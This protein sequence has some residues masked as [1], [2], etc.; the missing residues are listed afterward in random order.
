MQEMIKGILSFFS[1]ATAD[2]A[3]RILGAAA[4]VTGGWF[5]IKY[6]MRLFDRYSY[7]NKLDQG[8]MSFLSSL[9]KIALRSVLFIMAA[10]YLGVPNTSFI[11]ILSSIGLAVSLGLQGS[12]GNFAGGLMLLTFHPFRV[13]DY[14]Q[15]DQ[16]AGTVTSIN[17]LY[18]QL[19][20]FDNKLVIIPN[21]TLSNGVVT[22]YSALDT[23]RVDISFTVGAD[24][25]IDTVK[26]LMTRAAEEH[27][28]VLDDPKPDARMGGMVSG[29]MT[30]T[31]RCWVKT[32]DFWIVTYDL[33]ERLKNDFDLEKIHLPPPQSKV[34][35]VDGRQG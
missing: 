7:S 21:S 18:T 30:F 3:L 1:Q 32:P 8:V 16:A 27:P 15:T 9:L 29:L 31:L 12:L 13:G 35:I 33:N 6:V 26:R 23:R 25:G 34:Q 19:N 20:T 22:N 28:L 11:A 17:I 4:M 24:S 5:A 2:A 14:I 10:T